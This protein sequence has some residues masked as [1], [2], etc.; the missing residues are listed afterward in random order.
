MPLFRCSCR[1]VRE[2]DVIGALIPPEQPNA[3]RPAADAA[4]VSATA[5][6]S[7]GVGRSNSE[8]STIAEIL[9]LD[10]SALAV[11]L[12]FLDLSDVPSITCVCRHFHRVAYA[13]DGDRLLWSSLL[14]TH[15]P[16]L[17]ELFGT[18][19]RQYD[20]DMAKRMSYVLIK[21]APNRRF[22]RRKKKKKILKERVFSINNIHRDL[23]RRHFEICASSY[24][25]VHPMR[26]MQLYSDGSV[27]DFSDDYTDYRPAPHPMVDSLGR[28]ETLYREPTSN[29]D[30]YAILAE[31][32]LRTMTVEDDG[33]ATFGNDPNQPMFACILS[34]SSDL[35]WKQD[36]VKHVYFRQTAV[37]ERDIS[38]NAEDLATL[39]RV[40]T[41]QV[42]SA[43]VTFPA[44]MTISKINMDTGWQKLLYRTEICVWGKSV[45][46]APNIRNVVIEPFPIRY[47]EADFVP[48]VVQQMEHDGALSQGDIA[49]WKNNFFTSVYP[50]LRLSFD[51]SSCID[52]TDPLGPTF[53]D[54]LSSPMSATF[55]IATIKMQSG[56]RSPQ[57]SPAV[58]ELEL[59]KFLGCM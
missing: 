51:T 56:T 3:A 1:Q 20:E 25:Q 31:F 44:C 52:P 57:M 6:G 14:K 15:C 10:D 54:V 45:A 13:P 29:I 39:K 33:S 26:R 41:N 22:R 23:I 21:N 53:S 24:N 43:D 8:T 35:I 5:A 18:A 28:V 9:V 17:Y 36:N 11:A 30:R 46:R 19:N 59:Q 50:Q 55:S 12:S 47:D 7:S 40:F 48:F 2:S 37:Y 38:G 58:D 27:K 42:Y 49:F 16:S 34:S 4:D 32:K